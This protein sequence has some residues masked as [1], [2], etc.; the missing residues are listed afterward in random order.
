MDANNGT[1][2][3]AVPSLLFVLNGQQVDITMDEGLQVAKAVEN[4]AINIADLAA[5]FTAIASYRRRT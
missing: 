3:A 4:R 2:L 5:W 1:A